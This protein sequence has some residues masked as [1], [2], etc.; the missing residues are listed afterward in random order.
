[1][2]FISLLFNYFLYYKKV[3]SNVHNSYRYIFAKTFTSPYLDQLPVHIALFF[4][5]KSFTLITHQNTFFVK[6]KFRAV[7]RNFF[8]RR[9]LIII[10]LQA[11]SCTTTTTTQSECCKI[12][13][14]KGLSLFH[15][16]KGT[17]KLLVFVAQEQQSSVCW[18]K[19]I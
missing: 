5:T 16:L 4:R 6:P 12:P 15:S 2:Y 8:L 3:H 7:S 17:G 13:M 1:M 10:I 18:G 9:T 11:S 14:K 19:N